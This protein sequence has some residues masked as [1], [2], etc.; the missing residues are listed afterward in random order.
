MVKSPRLGWAV[1][2]TRSLAYSDCATSRSAQSSAQAPKIRSLLRS[3][4]RSALCLVFSL[5][6]GTR[7]K[8]AKTP[9]Q[10]IPLQLSLITL[11]GSFI[12]PENDCPC[13]QRLPPDCE[14]RFS[15]S[16]GHFNKITIFTETTARIICSC[17]RRRG[18]GKR[19][20][21]RL[22][23]VPQPLFGSIPIEPE[24]AGTAL[25]WGC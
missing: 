16:D 9:H 3:S 22:G 19:H 10:G 8:K 6:S 25:S 15:I 14:D 4:Q 12:I 11:A 5:R 13:H 7:S 1:N 18:D 21:S 2:D 23:N 24:D 20:Q 17:S